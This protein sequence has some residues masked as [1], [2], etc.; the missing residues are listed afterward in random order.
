MVPDTAT[1]FCRYSR[2]SLSGSRG[3]LR[4]DEGVDEGVG[5]S[6]SMQDNL[7]V[8]VG[9]LGSIKVSSV[10]LDGCLHLERQK[11]TSQVT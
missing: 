3:R 1:L 6:S 8:S 10:P 2:T 4:E 7:H 5:L 9:A 11:L